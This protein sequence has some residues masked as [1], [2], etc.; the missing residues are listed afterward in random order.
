ML[1]ILPIENDLCMI[2]NQFLHK[3]CINEVIESLKFSKVNIKN[4]QN[5]CL[6]ICQYGTCL[7][8][9]G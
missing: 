9:N 1:L 2:E 8:L 3:K 5:L 7:M 6:A 4:Y